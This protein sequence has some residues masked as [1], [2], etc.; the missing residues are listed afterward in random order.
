MKRSLR[1]WVTANE[2]TALSPTA[3][4]RTCAVLVA[5]KHDEEPSSDCTS[6]V[7]LVTRSRA[8]RLAGTK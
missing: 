6:V 2:E 1:C 4:A 8:M 5:G 3:S 7:E